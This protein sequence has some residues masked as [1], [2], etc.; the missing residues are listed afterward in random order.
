[1]SNY[2][3]LI[4]AHKQILNPVL[5][6][7]ARQ[8]QGDRKAAVFKT[9]P[10]TLILNHAVPNPSLRELTLKLDPGSRFLGIALLDGKR[11]IWAAELE[12]RGWQ[13]REKLEKR[14]SQRRSRRARKTGYRKCKGEFETKP[15]GWIGPSLMHRVQ[16]TMTWVKRLCALAPIHEIVVERVKFDMQ[17]LDNPDIEGVEYQ[18]GTLKGYTVREYLLEKWGRKCAYCQK[19]GMPLQIEHV[20]PRSKGGSNSIRN[21]CLACERC[22]IRKGTKSLDEFLKRKPEVL[23]RVKAT[24]KTRL[25]DAAAVNTTRNVLYRA[26]LDTGA[27]VLTGSGAQTKMNRVGQGLPKEHWIDAACVGD[28][29]TNIEIAVTQPLRIKAKGHGC[30]QMCNVNA[31]GFPKRRK[32]GSLES[33]KSRLCGPVRTG[34]ILNVTIPNGKYAGTYR[35]VRAMTRGDGRIAIK[36]KG[37]KEQFD[38]TVKSV[39]AL[40]IRPIC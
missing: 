8:M 5:P 6:G 20:I 14:A 23:K 17:L 4:D 11:V 25:S 24:Q 12:H 27:P 31:S 36:P 35:G 2:V 15:E 13:I 34:D 29:G 10:Y 19:E 32:D 7:L 18:Q 33:P 40:E 30:R 38:L 21:L 22:N 37:F 28:G 39:V 9:Y 16:T 3:F 1:M 26:L